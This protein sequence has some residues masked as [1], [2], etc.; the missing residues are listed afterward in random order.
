M[1][2]PQVATTQLVASELLLDRHASLSA[3]FESSHASGP[4][5][6]PV[7]QLASVHWKPSPQVA[8]TQL[9]ASLLLLLK[10]ASLSAVFESSQASGPS[11]APV[12]H[13]ASVH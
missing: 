2:S 11:F 4:S 9:V 5:F 8:T 10:H 12:V 3:V 13:E 1:P 6:A 7:V